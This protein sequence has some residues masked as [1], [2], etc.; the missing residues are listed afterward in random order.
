[1]MQNPTNF[2]LWDK[3]AGDG[4]VCRIH[5]NDIGIKRHAFKSEVPPLCLV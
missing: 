1:M 2:V 5:V 4:D 3:N